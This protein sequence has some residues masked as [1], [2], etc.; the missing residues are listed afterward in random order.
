VLLWRLSGLPK[1][2][3]GTAF[4]GRSYPE[5]EEALGLFT[6]YLQLGQQLSGE[7]SFSEVV[8]SVGRGLSEAHEWQE[9]FSWAESGGSGVGNGAGGR[10]ET[11]YCALAFGYEELPARL[12]VGE[13]QWSF[14]RLSSCVER[15]EVKL[16][17]QRR[18]Q[19]FELQWHYDAGRLNARAVERL[20]QQYAT[21]VAS[22]CAN[23]AAPIA[24]LAVVSAA[25]REELVV[26][27]NRTAVAYPEAGRCLPELFEAQVERSPTAI[28]VVY[29]GATLT[30][31]ELEQRA[32]QVAHYLQGQGL[33]AESVVGLL[34]E[35]SLELVVCLL[36]V[37]KAGAAYLPLDADYPEARLSYMLADAG[38]QLLL[39]EEWLLERVSEPKC[40]VLCVS[41][42]A[43]V[44]A[45][46]SR[47]RPTSTVSG[48]N[49]AYVIYTSGS[50]G[51]PKG[52]MI[53]HG[54]ISNHMQ[55]LGASYP[56]VSGSAGS[57]YT[58][59]ACGR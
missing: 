10:R 37:L 34:L 28:A 3:V 9:Y 45:G 40:A 54:A 24:E 13:L 56:L 12:T 35:R 57:A 53:T 58:P 11:Q 23:P 55:W 33:G 41:K 25:E 1:I 21:L 27:W 8:Q 22:A 36:G 20:A 46:Q 51:R 2:V 49:L 5:L 50:S 42:A 48:G 4:D 16:Q 29:E 19:Q 17:C 30:Y 52:V 43:A 38:V 39:T 59:R 47:T 44:L 32:N 18:E 15:Y 14:A 31:A 6:R 7:L 26:E